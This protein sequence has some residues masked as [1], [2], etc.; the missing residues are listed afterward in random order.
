MWRGS[1]SVYR[2]NLLKKSAKIPEIKGCPNC[3]FFIGA[4]VK[5]KMHHVQSDVCMAAFAALAA[6]TEL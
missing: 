2:A 4:G 5:R 3:M 6:L 1:S